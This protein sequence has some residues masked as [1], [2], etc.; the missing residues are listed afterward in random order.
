MAKGFFGVFAAF[1][2]KG[3]QKLAQNSFREN[4]SKGV[5]TFRQNSFREN[6]SKGIDALRHPQDYTNVK[7]VTDEPHTFTE[8]FKEGVDELTRER[9]VR[10]YRERTPREQTTTE[11]AQ[12]ELGLREEIQTSFNDENFAEA[13]NL[14]SHG[15]ASLLDYTHEGDLNS[16][17]RA[18]LSWAQ[19]KAFYM[20]TKSY[21]Q[22]EDPLTRNEIILEKMQ[23]EYAGKATINTLQ[24]AFYLVVNTNK[25]FISKYAEVLAEQLTDGKQETTD[26]PTTGEPEEKSRDTGS[27]PKYLR[28]YIN[29]LYGTE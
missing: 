27:P 12:E 22:G 18:A 20:L 16:T 7:D 14:A 25:E 28:S 5:Q 17:E 19:A 8:D 4:F 3:L 6:F 2:K 21:W 13:I 24:D 23:K 15:H 11:P 29:K 26:R 9:T 10:P 1:F